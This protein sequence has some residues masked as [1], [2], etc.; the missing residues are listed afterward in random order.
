MENLSLLKREIASPRYGSY[1][2]F[3]TNKIRRSDLKTLAESDANEVV[4]MLMEVPS[5]F[6]VLESHLFTTN[7]PRPVKNL[8]WNKSTGALQRCVDSLRS[9]LLA[10][11][12]PGATI[13]YMKDSPLAEELAQQV[14]DGSTHEG[15]SDTTLVILDRRIDPVTPLLNQWTYQAMI[16]ELIGTANNTV[17]LTGREDVPDDVK[18]MILSAE[19]DEFYKLNMYSNFGEIGQTIQTL[20]QNYQDK[21]KSHKKVDSIGDI[22]D[23]VSSYPEFKKMSGTV[24]K[25]L[26]L[27]GELSK[28]IK[29]NS[30]LEI[31]ECE[32]TLA[33]G[34]EKDNSV[35]ELQ[36]IL[37]LPNIRTKDALRLVSLFTLRYSREVE[38]HLDMLCRSVKGK[39]L[40]KNS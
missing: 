39:C 20:V 16:N 17:D 14:V 23:F 29:A 11:K 21:V 26:A 4:S 32:Q 31:S 13:A 22:K 5:D 2:V 6:Y 18:K 25:H 28:E 27:V 9:F 19:Y 34:L 15:S 3:F 35:Q 40:L 1:H 24:S 36:R 12:S 38:R 8:R 30:L 7:M 10:L 37:S 33:C